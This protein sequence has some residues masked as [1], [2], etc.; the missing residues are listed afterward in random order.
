MEWKDVGNAVK[1]ALPLI[2]TVLGGPMGGAAG[3]IIAMIASALGLKDDEATPENV[4]QLIQTDPQAMIKM[5]EIELNHKLELEKILL[6]YDRLYLQDRQGARDMNVKTTQA[7]GKR[8]VNLYV[9]AWVNV[10]GF[11]SVLMLVIIVKMPTDDVAKTAIAML[12]GALIA[13]YKDVL[14]YF[15]GSSK[16]SADKTQLLAGKNG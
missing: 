16:S 14:G 8:D 1:K 9:L 6:E 7:T 11:F 15:F 10:I 12:F 5:R 4:M 3:G 2:G 13:G